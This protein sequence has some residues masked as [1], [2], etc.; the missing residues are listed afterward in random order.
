MVVF[1]FS[2]GIWSVYI[3]GCE[4]NPMWWFLGVDLH[5]TPTLT[6]MDHEDW[7][8]EGMFASNL[9][10]LGTPKVHFNLFFLIGTPFLFK[11]RNKY[12]T[13]R[14]FEKGH[15]MFVTTRCDCWASGICFA[16]QVNPTVW[17]Q[18]P[19]NRIFD[20]WLSCCSNLRDSSPQIKV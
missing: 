2:F 7:F 13:L 16:V 5:P 20:L 12:S 11:V 14:C 1:T 18:G 19:D 17:F 8:S 10:Q 4:Y 3:L 9:W 6:S 15:D